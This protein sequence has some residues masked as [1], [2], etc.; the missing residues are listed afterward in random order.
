MLYEKEIINRMRGRI[1]KGIGG[2]YYVK[3]EQGVVQTRGRGL[4]RKTGITPMVGDEVEII[5]SKEDSDGDGMIQEILPRRNAFTRPPV[6]NVDT[7]VI[8]F[9]AKK[10]KPMFEIID[11]FLIT[12]ESNDAEPILCMNK[13]DLL[14]PEQ[15]EEIRG[16]YEGLYPFFSVS[17][18]TGEGLEELRQALAGRHTAFA[19]PSGVGKSSLINL[20]VPDA[21]METSSVSQKTRRGRHTT[22]HVEIFDY[23]LGGLIY[24]T[25]GFTSFDL[26]G[27]APEDLDQ[28]YPEMVP[29]I[30]QCRFDNCRHLKEPGCAVR[31]A[32]ERGEIS[33]D[34]YQSYVNGFEELQEKAQDWKNK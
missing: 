22:R 23:P 33:E 34:R 24:D 10:P 29:F 8:V 21:D 14:K 27:V 18:K 4:F 12:A 25:P 30:G 9:A 31:D 6:A 5:I 16:R 19:G 17:A 11:K 32:V 28:Y 1:I 13:C 2:F 3:T 15:L 7:V 26:S 20:I